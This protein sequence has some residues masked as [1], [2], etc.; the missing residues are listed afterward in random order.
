MGRAA[1]TTLRALSPAVVAQR[2]ATADR[3]RPSATV[4]G[5]C[6]DGTFHEHYRIG[7]M[8]EEPPRP[9][10]AACRRP[11]GPTVWLVSGVLTV[12]D[13]SLPAALHKLADHAQLCSAGF[14]TANIAGVILHDRLKLA[15]SLTLPTDEQLPALVDTPDPEANYRLLTITVTQYAGDA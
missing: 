14:A 8:N 13:T 15:W 9:A 2:I 6:S 3:T 7:P 11:A 1:L 12:A 10:P 4:H 5:G